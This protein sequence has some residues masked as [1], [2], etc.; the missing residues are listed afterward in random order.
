MARGSTIN[1][2]HNVERFLP[3]K[4]VIHPQLP[5]RMPCYDL[6]LIIDSTFVPSTGPSGISDSLDLTGECDR[7][8]FFAFP[9]NVRISRIRRVLSVHL[10]FQTLNFRNSSFRMMGLAQ[11]KI[12]DLTK[13]SEIFYPFALQWMPTEEWDD[14]VF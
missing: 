9:P 8:H 6:V 4:E 11:G 14:P 5:L 12:Q 13:E 1:L 10:G 3:R 2:Q 7:W